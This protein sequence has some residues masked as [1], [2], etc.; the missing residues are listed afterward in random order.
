M[1][2]KSAFMA[3]AVGAA[4]I[5]V[6]RKAYKKGPLHSAAPSSGKGFLP[7][8]AKPASLDKNGWN[9]MFWILPAAGA[10]YLSK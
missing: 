10:Y 9:A 1:S 7:A 5:F 4:A 6:A 3:G 2:V 8:V